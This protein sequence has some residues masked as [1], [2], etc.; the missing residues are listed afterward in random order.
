[1]TPM[2]DERMPAGSAPAGRPEG[3]GE[4]VPV[5]DGLRGLA[6]LGIVTYHAWLLSG[7]ARLDDGPVRDVLSSGFLSVALFFAL[8]GFV[9]FL[10]VV[11]AGG[12]FGS[13]RRYGLRRAAR[14]LPA[15]YAV[16]LV[17]AL[18]FPLLTTGERLADQ[19][20]PASL[21]A[22]LT[23][24]LNEA[25]LLPGYQGAL[26]LGVD[27]VLWTLSL[28][29]VFYAL[30][31]LVAGWFYRHPLPGLLIPL[32]A[33]LV[34]RLVLAGEPDGRTSALLLSSFPLHAAEFA[35]GM[36]A[37]VA[38]VRRRPPERLAAVLAVAGCATIVALLVA[39]GGPDGSDVRSAAQRDAFAMALLP[40]AC[41]VALLGLAAGPR[42][43]QAPLE[44]RPA[45]WL[46]SVSYGTFLVHFPVILLAVHALG[47]SR[48]GSGRAFVELAAFCV[49]VSLALGWLSW[50]AV[51]RPAR[52]LARRVTPVP[53][54]SATPEPAYQQRT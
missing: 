29:A 15:Y 13:V 8:S 52:R 14:I 33:G 21:V 30:L 31:P 44:C 34:L 42:V 35:A 50:V 12:A 19:V 41:A 16:L 2:A 45:R 6:A 46:G 37:A 39:L 26:G 54:A 22:H 27:P 7:Q 1:M 23:L 49:P 24:T 38:Y 40:V 10:P 20:S 53:R 36:L 32:G 5:L 48:D 9:L 51:E 43:L 4:S 47:F 3:G 17:C 25:R 11:R 28:E 18:A